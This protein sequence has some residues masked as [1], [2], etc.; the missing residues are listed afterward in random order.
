MLITY[1]YVYIL[2]FYL[3]LQTVLLYVGTRGSVVG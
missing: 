2:S 1:T 3:L